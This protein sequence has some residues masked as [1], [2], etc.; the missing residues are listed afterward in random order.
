MAE[1]QLDIGQRAAPSAPNENDLAGPA[2]GARTSTVPLIVDCDRT[3][4]RA[5]VAIE[6][7]VRVARR[8]V[9]E[10]LQHTAARDAVCW[11]FCSCLAGCSRGVQ[12][13]RRDWL[14]LIR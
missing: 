8:G 14:E 4:T 10:F 6:S 12:P 5:D 7:M 9:L 3:F 2:G 13:R 11:S 1:D